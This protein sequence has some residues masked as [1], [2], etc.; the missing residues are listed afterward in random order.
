MA[1]GFALAVD[2]L[3]RGVLIG[4]RMAGLG[5]GIARRELGHSKIPVQVSAEPVFHVDGRSRNELRPGVVVDLATPGA[6][7]ILEA[8]RA[9]ARAALAAR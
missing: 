5:A 8:G 7:P 1:E 2:S 6:D 3:H 9:A 4:T